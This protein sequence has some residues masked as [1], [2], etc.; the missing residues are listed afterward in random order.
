MTRP[1][2]HTD[3]VQGTDEWKRI[4]S[5][6][7]TGSRIE[8]VLMATTTASYQNYLYEIVSERMTGE[9]TPEGF[10]NQAIRDGKER[11]PVMRSLYE[12]RQDVLVQEVGFID[13]P[14][15]AGFGVS[16]DGVMPEIRGGLEGKCPLLATHAK[17][18][19]TGA[20]PRGYYLQMQALMECAAL[21][22]CDF[23]SFHPRLPEAQRLYIKRVW[24]DESTIRIIKDGVVRF[25]EDVEATIAKLERATYVDLGR[26]A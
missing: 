5:G 14:T 1:N 25:L 20:V 18:V 9:P 19:L 12:E 4:R 13:H 7:A 23:V 11:E 15:L 17:Y 2:W 16:P 8:D 24:R 21:E 22:W 10:V 6:K 26:K 3:I